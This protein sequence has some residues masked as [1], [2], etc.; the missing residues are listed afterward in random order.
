MEWGHTKWARKPPRTGECWCLG[1]S[2]VVGLMLFDHL[3][4][5]DWVPAPEFGP[6]MQYI[7]T[8]RN[9]PVRVYNRVDS[10]FI[11]DDFYVKLKMFSEKK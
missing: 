8:G 5:F 9:R 2:P 3:H 6:N 10:R 4:D 7:H 11:L 1:D